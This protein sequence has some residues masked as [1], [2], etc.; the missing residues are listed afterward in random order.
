LGFYLTALDEINYKGNYTAEKEG[1]TKTTEK[2]T[3]LKYQY[4][5]QRT[6][7]NNFQYRK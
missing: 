5:K 4:V 2:I 7:R 6:C 1:K 3:A